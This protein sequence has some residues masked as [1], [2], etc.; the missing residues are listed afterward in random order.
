VSRGRADAV[1]GW[2][3]RPAAPVG[4]SAPGGRT[5]AAVSP[6]TTLI[7]RR[8]ERDRL[9]EALGGAGRGEGRLVL[10]A[11]EAGVGK[12]RLVAELT[13]GRG[14]VVMSG[15]AGHG[16]R[17]P[18]GPLAEALRGPLRRRPE[19]LAEAGPLRDQ[20]A[21]VLPEL[22]PPPGERERATLVEAVCRLLGALASERPALLHLDD[23]HWSDE[24]TIELLSAIARPLRDLPVLVV[25]AYRSDGLPRDH[26]LRRMRHELRRLGSLDEIALG[27]LSP[28]ETS[29]LA[30]AVLGRPV[31]P[32]LARMLYGRSQGLPFFVEELARALS[33]A[34]ALEDGPDGVTLAGESDVAVPETIRDAV[35]MAAL[36]LTPGAR[37]AADV[38]A[39][40]GAGF[41]PGLVE[42]VSGTEGLAE[43]ADR[44]WVSAD[45]AGR[46]AF[47]HALTREALYADLPWLRRRALHRELAE[48]LEEAG[49]PAAEVAAHWMGAG[50][51]DRARP[52]FVRAARELHAVHAY[53]DAAA[54]ARQALEL[55]PE[56]EEVPERIEALSSYAASA[57]L[58]GEHAEAARAWREVC[59][60]A[61]ATSVA[62]LL[63]DANR[64]LAAVHDLRGDRDSALAA[65]RAAADAFARAGRPA[66]AAIEHLGAAGYLRAR[67]DYTAAI[68]EA[69]SAGLEAERAGRTD[70]RLR[71]RGLE[72]VA[73]AKR[74]QHAE[75]LAQVREALAVAL[76]EGL[77][78]QAAE[79]YQR[80]SLVVYDAGDY[81]SAEG[82]LDTALE[83]CE[84]S[85]RGD[86]AVACMTCM[87][88]V[89]RECGEWTRAIELARQVIAGGDGA[90]VAE[91]LAGAILAYQGNA[92]GARGLLTSSLR[93]SARVDHFNM[94]VDSTTA[95]GWMAAAA[96]DDEEAARRYREVL[97]RWERSEDRHYALRGLRWAAG[98]FAR[99]GQEPAAHACTAALSGIAATTG[100]PDALAALA[101]AI[102]ET[103]LAEGDAETAAD[104]LVRAADL[105]R[106][107]EVPLDGA[108]ISLRAGVALRAAGDGEGALERLEDAYRVARRLGARPLAAEAAR[109]V[110]EAG[111]EAAARLGRRAASD[112]EGGGL[113]RRELEVIRLV[114]AGRTNREIAEELYLSPRTIDM[115]MRSVLRR[116]G[117]R[118]RMEAA[119]RAGELGLLA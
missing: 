58:A 66:D 110:A 96:G 32:P 90:W 70:L 103:A 111:P 44:G 33:S 91:G 18:F 101:A 61:M 28:D 45:G 1:V 115:H 10:V 80:L 114:A 21:L 19:V 89:L 108:D 12:T 9:A 22:G 30:E 35:I 81:R 7:G 87:V 112:A 88:F 95:L 65:R 106:G 62:G 73:R 72:G 51:A 6:A 16:D 97:A 54:A 17:S 27:P 40:A 63:G 118:S 29:D 83:L 68:E 4:G 71:A 31:A 116:L 34:D 41:D 86:V 46:L 76:A 20:L 107:L 59:D 24:A 25:A 52:L 15:R 57:E 75:G 84:T 102:G 82:T 8:A 69:S 99:A 100:H 47:R 64:R 104:Q 74:G 98:F 67:A 43:L 36:E 2:G 38:A 14:L 79:L 105:Q 50:A 39:V 11:G 23:L 49:A 13:A 92:R 78:P 117:C 3:L 53:R 26:A 109:L 37:V 60:L 55:W 77:T 42:A 119:R 93:V 85:P 5:L 48:R 113:S 56:G 94:A